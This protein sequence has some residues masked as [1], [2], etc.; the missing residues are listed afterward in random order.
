MRAWNEALRWCQE[1]TRQ[2]AAVTLIA[3]SEKLDEKN[4]TDRLGQ[5]PE[6]GRLNLAGLQSV[7][8][9]RVLFK[10]PPPMGKN[11]TAYYDEGFSAAASK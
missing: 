1:E 7:L 8:D 10:L 4:A 2:S 6:D 9:L 3:E 11:L 5:L